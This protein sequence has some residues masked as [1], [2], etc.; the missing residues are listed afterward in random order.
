MMIGYNMYIYM[1]IL[2]MFVWNITAHIIYPVVYPVLSCSMIMILSRGGLRLLAM[3][4]GQFVLTF[5][6]PFVAGRIGLVWCHDS[7][8]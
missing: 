3:P 5:V 1:Y 8:N 2:C 6:L 4:V 7:S